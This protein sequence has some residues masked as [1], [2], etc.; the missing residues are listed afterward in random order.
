MKYMIMILLIKF[1]EII[2][3]DNKIKEINEKINDNQEISE[4]ILEEESN[5]FEIIEINESTL[6]K[7]SGKENKRFKKLINIIINDYKNYPNFTHYF[8][9]KN[10]LYFLKLKINQLKKRKI[11]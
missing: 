2:I 6:E 3:E 4:E 11:L 5:N 8:N 1:D 9:I 7:I 10:L